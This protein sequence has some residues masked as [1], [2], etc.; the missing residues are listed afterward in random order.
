M[1]ILIVAEHDN[2]ALK[3]AT[4]NTL[5]AAREIGGDIDMLVAGSGCRGAA[6]AA[7]TLDGVSRVL[8]AEAPELAHLLAENMAPLIA[9]MVTAAG[10]WAGATNLT[11][12]C[13]VIGLIAAVALLRLDRL[14]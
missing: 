4:L 6:E 7:A 10:S 14:R 5:A 12:S 11:A 2:S 8:I 9:A 3:P 1:G 13:A